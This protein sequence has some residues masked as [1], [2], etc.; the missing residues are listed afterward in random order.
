MTCTMYG[1][2]V[3][4]SSRLGHKFVI[5]NL[6]ETCAST[7]NDRLI[8]VSLFSCRFRGNVGCCG[9]CSWNEK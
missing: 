2:A 1:L 5:K 9:V 6:I 8:G 4:L 3:P 7:N